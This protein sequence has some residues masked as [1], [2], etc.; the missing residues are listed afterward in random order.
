MTANLDVTRE[1]LDRLVITRH[2]GDPAGYRTL[3]AFPFPDAPEL[4]LNASTGGSISVTIKL[5]PVEAAAVGSFLVDWARAAD[6]EEPAGLDPGL[7]DPMAE[8]E[9]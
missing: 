9:A 8:V 3:S 7:P 6:T 2:H 4:L 1:G 5:D